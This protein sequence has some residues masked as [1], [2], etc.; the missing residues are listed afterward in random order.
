MPLITT[1]CAGE[2]VFIRLW[3]RYGGNMLFAA[4]TLPDADDVPGA[5]EEKAEKIDQMDE[6]W[7]PYEV[8]GMVPARP[9]MLGAR[10]IHAWALR[11]PPAF[12]LP[13][14]HIGTA[15]WHLPVSAPSCIVNFIS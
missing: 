2:A 10:G 1:F 8:G 15:G 5:E 7:D 12:C 14:R 6:E 11:E 4:T 9:S 13:G 3:A